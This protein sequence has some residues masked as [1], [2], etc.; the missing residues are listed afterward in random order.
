[1]GRHGRMNNGFAK[2]IPRGPSIRINKAPF[3]VL[4]G[5]F[6]R[7]IPGVKQRSTALVVAY[8][9]LWRGRNLFLVI[10]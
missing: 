8:Y 10:R 2:Q 7:Q 9:T 3:W 4:Q 6:A 1:M 5:G